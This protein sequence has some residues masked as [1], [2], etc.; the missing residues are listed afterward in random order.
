VRPAATALLDQADAASVHANATMAAIARIEGT[1]VL[2][3][4]PGT[5]M[6]TLITRMQARGLAGQLTLCPH[7]TYTSPAPAYWCA[8]APGRLRCAPC[9]AAANNRIRGTREDRRCDHCRTVAASIHPDMVQLPPVVVDLP[10]YPPKCVPPITMQFGLCP[11]C[12]LAD[13]QED[14]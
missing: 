13:H 14:Q 1:P 11:P 6:R 5:V 3:V 4:E 12:Q 9:A 2:N 7:L 8:W 10:P